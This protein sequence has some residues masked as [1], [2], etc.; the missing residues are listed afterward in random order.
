MQGS[1]LFFEGRY[2]DNVFTRRR[3]MTALAWPKPKLKLDFRGEAFK[4]RP[5]A[6]RVEEI[7]LQSLWAEP[8]EES[9]MREPLALEVRPAHVIVRKRILQTGSF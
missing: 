9:Y 6:P 7:N 5:G 4:W 8:G 3:G 1:A 2:Y